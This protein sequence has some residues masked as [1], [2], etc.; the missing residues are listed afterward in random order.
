MQLNVKYLV[1]SRKEIQDPSLYYF[2]VSLFRNSDLQIYTYGT[3]ASIRYRV[4]TA[5][6]T[7]LR[8]PHDQYRGRLNRFRASMIGPR[9]V[10]LGIHAKRL[11]KCVKTMIEGPQ[12]ERHSVPSYPG[13]RA[14]Q[15]ALRLASKCQDIF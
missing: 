10:R 7:G 3:E 2:I 1:I 6:A 5:H 13:E 12:D 14:S 8:C 4:Y 11:Q 9:K 15:G